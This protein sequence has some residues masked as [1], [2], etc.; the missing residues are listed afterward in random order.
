MV[1]FGLSSARLIVETYTQDVGPEGGL[2]NAIVYDH[3]LT[4]QQSRAAWEVGWTRIT[5]PRPH[6]LLADLTLLYTYGTAICPWVE[7][8]QL[9]CPIARQRAS[10]AVLTQRQAGCCVPVEHTWQIFKQAHTRRTVRFRAIRLPG[11][12]RQVLA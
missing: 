7:G 10:L 9:C 4:G 8:P 5:S 3:C 12:D 2:T 1:G 6:R 11:L